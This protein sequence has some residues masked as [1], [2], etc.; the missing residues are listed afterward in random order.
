MTE[1]TSAAVAVDPQQ[2]EAARTIL[3]QQDGVDWLLAWIIGFAEQGLEMGVT[4]NV[5][6]VLITGNLIGGRKYFET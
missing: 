3:D 6:G 2:P 4:L 5:G 1:E